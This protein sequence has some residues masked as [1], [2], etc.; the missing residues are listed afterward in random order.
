M[1]KLLCVLLV[2]VMI[3]SL[4]ACGDAQDEKN[5]AG[6]ETTSEQDQ[7]E[8]TAPV[9]TTTPETTA[10]AT[11]VPAT[12]EPTVHEHNY[13]GK[14]TKE[15]T[16]SEKGVK[17]FTCACG[18][19][20]TKDI[21][22]LSHKYSEATCTAAKTC[23]V[24]GKTDGKPAAHTYVGGKCTVC[25]AAQKD[26]KDITAEGSW[27]AYVVCDD[28]E[29]EKL[30]FTFD[31]TGGRFGVSIYNP[32]SMMLDAECV[33]IDGKKW[34]EA[35]FG[36]SAEW[37]EFVEDGNTVTVNLEIHG[38]KSTVVL[39]RIAGNKLKTKSVSG[40]VKDAMI[41]EAVK[42]ATFEFVSRG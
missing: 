21:K 3:L 16:C 29:M 13:T 4:C 6:G 33:E 32:E 14:V 17:T 35:G 34:Y 28:Q 11:T 15:A 22:K 1:K 19:S 39:E 5:P 8:T 42:G 7:N 27:R 9:E 37:M 2:L 20:Y 41:T 12:T 24:C 36:Y 26:Y 31:K 30:T 23:S 10:P 40:K 25:S 38:V 18:D